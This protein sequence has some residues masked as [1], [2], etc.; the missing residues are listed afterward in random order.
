[1]DRSVIAGA[2]VIDRRSFF[3]TVGVALGGATALSILPASGLFARPANVMVQ[4]PSTDTPPDGVWN[5]DSVFGH[6][7]AYSHPIGHSRAAAYPVD[8]ADVHPAD[9]NFLA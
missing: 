5:V 7:P 8:V 6:F 9:L 2:A 1:M 3:A 4:F